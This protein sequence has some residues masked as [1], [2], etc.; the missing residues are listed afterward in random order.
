MTAAAIAALLTL[1]GEA[2]TQAPSLIADVEALIAGVKKTLAGGDP[3][4][5]PLAPVVTA[6]TAALAAELTPKA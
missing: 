1:I 3:S 6:E 4:V 2:I 5:I